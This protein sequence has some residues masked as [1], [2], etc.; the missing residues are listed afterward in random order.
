MRSGTLPARQKAQGPKALLPPSLVFELAYALGCAGIGLLYHQAGGTPHHALLLGLVPFLGRPLYHLVNL[1]RLIARRHRLAPPFPRGGWGDIYRALAQYQQDARRWR[2]RQA[3]YALRFREV[4]NSVPDGLIMLDKAQRVVWANEG[5]GALMNLSWP[6]DDGCHIS[7]F[8][9]HPDLAPLIEGADYGHSLELTPLHNQAIKLSL[10]ISP[11]GERKSQRLIV[12]RD[13]TAVYH[14]NMTRRDFVAN[15]SHELRTPLTVIAGFLETLGDSPLT[16]GAHR[17]PIELMVSQTRRMRS[18][19]EDLLTLSR[20]EMG[21]QSEHT[22][23]ADVPAEIH[24]IVHEAEALSEGR[25]AIDLDL[26]P[27]LLLIGNPV[28]LRSA[29]SNLVF[30]AIQHTPHGS[31][32]HISWLKKAGQPVFAV[33]DDGEGIAQEHIP[34]LTER[35]YRVDTGRSRAS[36][37]TGLGLA[38]VNHVL[39]RH[40]AQLL[41]SSEPGKGSTFACRFPARSAIER[42]KPQDL[43]SQPA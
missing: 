9:S 16:P 33:S 43:S 22:E 25:Q 39:N 38:I 8:L 37:G 19:V 13:I 26:D 27:N 40:D 18:I 32:V 1:T 35:F 4:A 34:R 2:K 23:P 5:A 7:E 14:L 17:R 10:R 42:C 31:R 24:A 11:F 20:L 15:A 30:N 6:R 28:E 29:F 21:Q 12:A 3:R 36:G 41:I